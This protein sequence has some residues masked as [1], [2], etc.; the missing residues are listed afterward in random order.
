MHSTQT[1]RETDDPHDAPAMAPDVVSAAW[2]DKVLA[3]INRAAKVANHVL[4]QAPDQLPRTPSSALAAPAPTVDTTFRAA[5]VGDI[6][7][8]VARPPKSKWAAHVTMIFMFALVSAF[9]AGLW[10]HYGATARQ[11]IA[12]WTP[13][14]VAE[15]A[16]QFTLAS[17]SEQAAPAEQATADQTAA[18]DQPA[19]QTASATQPA[20]A[21][22]VPPESADLIQSMSRDLAAMGRQIEQLKAS[23]AELKS[24]QQSSSPA[25]ARTTEAKPAEIR[26][27]APPPVARP[28]MSAAVPPPP[29]P[30]PVASPVRRPAPVQASTA[31]IQLTAPPPPPAYASPPQATARPDDEPV[32]RPPMPLR[33]GTV[34]D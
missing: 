13:P 29:A 12:E 23:I 11:L 24:N 20:D 10:N 14:A 1:L 33:W 5:A 21:A 4:S 19:S 32:V 3:D 25:I 34:S 15:W 30:R 31:P 6:K 9:A 7:P 17:T 28:K 22:A 2:A 18:A 27:P 26:S 16:P 8:A